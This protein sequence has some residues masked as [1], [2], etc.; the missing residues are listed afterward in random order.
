MGL[1]TFAAGILFAF[2]RVGIDSG[3]NGGHCRFA[4][5]FA[6]RFDDGDLLPAPL[7]SCR[8]GRRKARCVGARTFVRRPEPL[9]RPL[10]VD[11]DLNNPYS[12]TA[13][14]AIAERDAAASDVDSRPIG[15][16][17][18]RQP[19]TFRSRVDL[20]DVARARC[21]EVIAGV[22]HGLPTQTS[23]TEGPRAPMMPVSPESEKPFISKRIRTHTHPKP[24]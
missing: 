6:A 23:H 24:H 12:D 5:C 13:A 20:A 1:G 8:D 22:D 9:F 3:P 15:V 10:A 4:G 7:E 18:P 16:L 2:G 14:F 11:Y 21:S 17:S 19:G